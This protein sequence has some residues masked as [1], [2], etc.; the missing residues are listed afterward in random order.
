MLIICAIVLPHPEAYATSWFR[1]G[2]PHQQAVDKI[3]L[4]ARHAAYRHA[5]TEPFINEVIA[6]QRTGSSR[7]HDALEKELVEKREKMP[8]ANIEEFS[9]AEHFYDQPLDHFN[10]I[11]FSDV[12]NSWKQRYFTL[13]KTEGLPEH[14]RHDHKIP[15]SGLRAGVSENCKGVRRPIFIYVG[16]EGPLTE[17]ALKIGMVQEMARKFGADLFGLEHRYYGKSHPRPDSRVENLQ[18]LT[19]EQALADLG[20]F[21]AHLKKSRAEHC[22]LDY[23][24]IPVVVFGCSYP[25]ALAAYF[26]S[27]YPAA[28]L[29]AVA[30][31]SPVEA[32]ENF[33]QYD[34][35][36]KS[37]L[38]GECVDII[39]AA[40]RIVESYLFS[41]KSS[42]E[43][44]Q[45]GS[46]VLH[47]LEPA[48]KLINLFGCSD[49]PTSADDDKVGFLY[50]LADSVASAVQYNRRPERPL[51]KNL[52]DEVGKARDGVPLDR[53][54]LERL[55]QIDPKIS[56]EAAKLLYSFSKAVRM[57]LREFG[58]T[59]EQANMRQLTD[60]SL[61]ETQS[62]SA[63]L[64]AWQSC[65]EYGFW[66]TGYPRS[67]R[68]ERIDLA[69]HLRACNKI[70]PLAKGQFVSNVATQNNIWT[71]GRNLATL[72]AST[73]IHFTNGGSDP[74]AN[75]SV[76]SISDEIRKRQSLNSFVI[77][78]ASHCRDFG[79]TL[80]TD[81]EELA[82]AR[83][84]IGEAIRQWL[85]DFFDP[86]S[87]RFITEK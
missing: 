44:S 29:G 42:V 32:V 1:K 15:S 13:Q 68:S 27:K 72:G 6:E 62:A 54:E 16:G 66:Q 49:I 5:E 17:D 39:Q 4:K 52:C 18:W 35:T 10:P 41:A 48:K 59:C 20:R 65:S 80:A 2:L 47:E 38:P 36:V 87:K 40:T 21:V 57:M 78:G 83:R 58:E 82:K 85:Q 55:Q 75:L 23:L 9:V 76:T 30:S 46:D 33:T 77:A 31:S 8:D 81:S 11:L 45:D 14:A 7:T 53:D 51:I 24:D 86:T 70:F 56:M 61:G 3:L 26:R 22:G 67:V 73:N 71:G 63:R 74:W 69:W 60:L 37:Q 79:A 34:A 25:G 12:S 43:T 50:V 19:S 28:I 84:E 64:W